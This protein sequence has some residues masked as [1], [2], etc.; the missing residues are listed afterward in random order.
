MTSSNKDFQDKTEALAFHFKKIIE[1]LGDDPDREGLV[2]TPV[3]A[4]KAML[5]A[6]Q[7]YDMD[8]QQVITQAIFEDGG[9]RMVVVK[10]IEFYSFCEHHILPFFGTVSIG[11]VPDGKMVGLSKLARL[12]NVV[13]RRLQVQERLTAEIC[14]AV[15]K[16]LAPKGVIVV[17]RAQHLCMKMRGVEKQDSSTEPIHDTGVFRK[18]MALRNDFFEAIR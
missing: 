17:C 13:A 7:G 14:E 10:E 9:S 1:L 16:A 12:V 6:T 3:R 11:Y 8:P 18:D 5:F 2:K 4:A 15:N